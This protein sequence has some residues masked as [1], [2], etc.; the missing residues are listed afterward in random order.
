MTAQNVEEAIRNNLLIPVTEVAC[1]G[2]S[3]VS[4][5]QHPVPHY[6]KWLMNPVFNPIGA[7]RQPGGVNYPYG[8]Q[9]ITAYL[10]GAELTIKV[11][12]LVEDAFFDFSLDDFSVPHGTT[13]SAT[14]TLRA[15][16]SEF[17]HAIRGFTEDHG[18]EDHRELADTVTYDLFF[19]LGRPQQY[20]EWMMLAAKY[21][22]EKE[23]L[24]EKNTLLGNQ[25]LALEDAKTA[26]DKKLVAN[27]NLYQTLQRQSD[28]A[29]S[30]HLKAQAKAMAEKDEFADYTVKALVDMKTPKDI[31]NYRTKH[32]PSLVQGQVLDALLKTHETL[33]GLQAQRGQ[34]RAAKASTKQKL[35]ANGE[36]QTNVRQTRNRARHDYKKFSTG[37]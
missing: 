17:V 12:V 3:A 15:F 25:L 21:A 6:R 27:V 26:L 19:I 9:L 1:S 4:R 16:S 32:K 30:A 35:V 31:E 11:R 10:R 34:V 2:M 37:N 29:R 36:Q 14:M 33:L 24:Q 20:L 5:D 13:D 22:V 28:D 18:F 7:L 8:N 23:G